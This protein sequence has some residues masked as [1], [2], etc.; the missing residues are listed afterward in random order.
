[1]H[2]FFINEARGLVAVHLMQRQ[3]LSLQIF[4]YS[5]LSHISTVLAHPKRILGI[6]IFAVNPFLRTSAKLGR[7]SFRPRQTFWSLYGQT[8][9]FIHQCD[10]VW[11][12]HLILGWIFVLGLGRRPNI[13]TNNTLLGPRTLHYHFSLQIYMSLIARNDLD[14][15]MIEI[16]L[17]L[18]ENFTNWCDN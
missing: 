4:W 11:R 5:S 9:P 3:Q 12:R 17:I 7:G 18:L 6:A 16:L 13:W 10:F 2:H 14:G 1:M 8:P 15:K